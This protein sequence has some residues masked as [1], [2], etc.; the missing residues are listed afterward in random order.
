MKQHV[1]FDGRNQY[2]LK[3]IAAEGFEYYGIGREQLSGARKRLRA[4]AQY[5]SFLR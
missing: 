5:L 1:I 3:Q 4:S 2:D